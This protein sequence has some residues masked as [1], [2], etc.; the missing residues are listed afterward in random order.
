M[1]PRRSTKR[2]Y[3]EPPVDEVSIKK[4]KQTDGKREV[5]PSPSSSDFSPDE[6]E[7]HS[8]LAPEDPNYVDYSA[9]SQGD[10][11]EGSSLPTRQQR[12]KHNGDEPI[13]DPTL[14]PEGW[15]ANELD[16]D[17]NDIDSQIERCVERISDGILPDFFKF[18]LSQYERRRAAR[19]EMVHSEPAGLSWDIVRR[20]N[21]L[22]EI[23]AHLNTNRDPDNQLPNV[24]ALTKAY[25]E[26]NLGWSR[27]LVSY[28]S[29]GVQLNEPQKFD[30]EFHKNL[31]KQ[32]DT[33][34]AWWV[35]G[36]LPPGHGN[37]GALHSFPSH[38]SYHSVKFPVD[39]SVDSQRNG[40]GGINMLTLH[41]TGADIMGIPQC[42]IDQLEA[43]GLPVYVQG[44]NIMTIPG[45]WSCHKIVEIDVRLTDA[46][47]APLSHWTRVQACVMKSL[48]GDT[49]GMTLSGPFL[50]F[51]LYTATCPDGQGL[52]YVCDHKKDLRKLPALPND[53][54]PRVPP[55][56]PT[57]PP[58]PGVDN[59]LSL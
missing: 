32:Y 58:A 35:E 56:L 50:R 15:N 47:G 3:S 2:A 25:R 1:P 34:K 57:A 8:P 7:G 20:L 45:G 28:W 5:S 13:T 36:L 44:Y 30:A 27:G 53:F 54:V 46:N 23:E 59:H 33:T 40:L 42:Y 14:V 24:K 51:V 22:K 37:L 21:H 12:W 31:A 6:G 10:Q 48:P 19:D 29:N 9:M 49:F 39:I 52:L 11:H 55:H 26:G 4:R 41:D 16:L 18:R 17:V 38:T 43:M